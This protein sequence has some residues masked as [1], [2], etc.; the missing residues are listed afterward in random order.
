MNFTFFFLFYQYATLSSRAADGRQMYTEGSVV[1]KASKV[2]P[3]I[4]PTPPLIFTGGQKC[5][6]WRRFQHYSTF[7]MMMIM[8]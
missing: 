5:E 3:E 8:S 6:I 2:G 4:S 1:C 7:V